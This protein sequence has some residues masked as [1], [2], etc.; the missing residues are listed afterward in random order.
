MTTPLLTERIPRRRACKDMQILLKKSTM[1]R[2]FPSPWQ[3][4]GE[5]HDHTYGLKWQ[6][7]KN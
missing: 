6:M 3:N 2:Q 1:A 7:L 5:T 4:V